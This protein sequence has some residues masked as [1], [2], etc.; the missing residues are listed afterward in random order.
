LSRRGRLL[1][2]SRCSRCSHILPARAVVV[3]KPLQRPAEPGARSTDVRVHGAV[4]LVRGGLVSLVD[5]LARVL[6]RLLLLVVCAHGRRRGMVL[7]GRRRLLRRGLLCP[8]AVVLRV[9]GLAVRGLLHVQRPAGLRPSRWSIL[10]IVGI[11]GAVLRKRG[12][13]AGDGGRLAVL[14]RRQLA[15]LALLLRGVAVVLVVVAHRGR[16][17]G[18]RCWIRGSCVMLEGWPRASM[19]APSSWAARKG[20][21]ERRGGSGTDQDMEVAMDRLDGGEWLVWDGLKT[22]TPPG[23]DADHVPNVWQI[24]GRGTLLVQLHGR[25]TKLA[26]RQELSVR[27][28]LTCFLLGRGKLSHRT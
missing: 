28:A 11:R 10:R 17:T 23:R 19:A 2:G 21:A 13:V 20:R 27:F 14:V 5:L 7:Q 4:R 25:R 26:P 12:R 16:A 9:R 15:I 8:A 22:G 3:E 18:S 6:V 1:P 24:G